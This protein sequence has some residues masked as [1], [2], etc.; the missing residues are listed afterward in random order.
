[1]PTSFSRLHS[2]LWGV[3]YTKSVF[4]WVVHQFQC[5]ACKES[6]NSTVTLVSMLF[7]HRPLVYD[8]TTVRPS[9]NIRSI[10]IS[11][12]SCNV[13]SRF[14][15]PSVVAA[16]VAQSAQ[17]TPT[18]SQNRLKLQRIPSCASALSLSIAVPIAAMKDWIGKSQF[19]GVYHAYVM[20]DHSLANIESIRA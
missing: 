5:K 3:F 16:Q 4:V 8:G 20:M 17:C 1:M 11:S 10:S 19:R 14:Y 9:C 12:T 18:D 6:G 7:S 2:P 15:N 13:L